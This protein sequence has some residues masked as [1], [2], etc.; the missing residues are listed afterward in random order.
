MN[1]PK[2]NY[3]TLVEYILRIYI[4]T[5]YSNKKGIYNYGFYLM[6]LLNIPFL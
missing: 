6:E 1:V 5:S 3:K 2:Q 4:S